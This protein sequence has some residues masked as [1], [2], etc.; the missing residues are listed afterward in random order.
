M[1]GLNPFWLSFLF[2]GLLIGP[3]WGTAG[4]FSRVALTSHFAC[5]DLGS[6]EYRPY[7]LQAVD[8]G[9]SYK[10]YSQTSKGLLGQDPMTSIDECNQAVAA[11]NNQFGVVCSRTG[12]DGWKPTL[13]TGTVPGRADYGY[14]GG[15]SIMQFSDCLEA[16]QNSSQ[17]GVCFW[18]GSGWY[19]SPIDREGLTGGPYDSVDEC[20]THTRTE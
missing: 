12:L 7:F 5:R 15:S 4:N 16:T 19:I 3:Q 11:A 14:L 17:S 1:N 9:T 13:Y 18:G 2:F 6:G 20:V 10:D 8:N